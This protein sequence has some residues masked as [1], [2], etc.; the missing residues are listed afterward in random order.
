MIGGKNCPPTEADASTAPATCA[1]KPV[2]FIKGMVNVPVVTVFAIALPATEPKKP[3]VT[4]ET[5][6][7]PP[8]E[9][10]ASDIGK[11]IKNCPTPDFSKNAPKKIKRMT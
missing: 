11:L 4:T 6:A 5:F 8:I 1:L 9:R 2:R 7:A 3:D 10:P